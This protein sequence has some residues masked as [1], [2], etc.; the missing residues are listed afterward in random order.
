MQAEVVK[1]N[2]RYLL[3][4]GIA[5]RFETALS[6]GTVVPVW[7][8]GQ[9][10]VLTDENRF[11][12]AELALQTRLQ[13]EHA[14]MESIHRGLC[15]LVPCF[16]LNLF[17]W[18]E[19]E[20]LITGQPEID[21][22]LLREHTWRGSDEEEKDVIDNLWQVCTLGSVLRYLVFTESSMWYQNP[23]MVVYFRHCS[24]RQR[25][26]FHLSPV[27]T[28]THSK[29]K[30]LCLWLSLN[31]LTSDENSGVADF[32]APRSLSLFAIRM[33]PQPPAKAIRIH[34]VL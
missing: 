28:I 31:L 8:D 29:K 32:L 33:R 26:V 34:G 17:D 19:L 30:H 24:F 11:E 3:V 15:S 20:G 16:S 22:A 23:E 6:D 18:W 4:E 21:L 25:T 7:R 12:Y 14:Q 2:H 1:E 10:R 13:E 5:G 27:M 9:D